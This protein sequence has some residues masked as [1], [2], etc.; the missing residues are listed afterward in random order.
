MVTEFL[1]TSFTVFFSSIPFVPASVALIV[2]SL[3]L[4]NFSMAWTHI[5][6]SEPSPKRWYRRIPSMSVWKKIALPT[7]V[8]ALAKNL[9]FL[10]PMLLAK[11]YHFEKLPNNPS[12]MTGGQ[13]VIVILKVLSVCLSSIVMAFIF[14]FPANV[15]LTRVQ[16]SLLDDADETIVPFDRSF[17]G[18][19][20]PEI[21]GGTGVI[22]MVDAWKTFDWASRIRLVKA[23]AKVIALQFIVMVLFFAILSIEIFAIAQVDLKK[24][25]PDGGKG[26]GEF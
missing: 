4:A 6:I 17:G 25:L 10:L 9:T 23:Y 21:V 8:A 15:V 1:L 26:D 2:A 22:S 19:V 14:T 16:A 13:A 24:L 7:A 20:V 5:V 3:V 18:K 11:L 12:P